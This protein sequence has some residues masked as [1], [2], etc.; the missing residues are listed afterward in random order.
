MRTA[1]CSPRRNVR[2][3]VA[4][5]AATIILTSNA[6]P[7]PTSVA[8]QTF[9]QDSPRDP[10]DTPVTPQP[11]DRCT[12]PTDPTC[13][14]AVYKGAPDDYAQVQDIPAWVL[15]HPD[16]DGRYQ[17]ERGQQITVVTA[18]PLPSRLHPLLPPAPTAAGH[19]QSDIIPSS[20]S[21]RSG[22]LTPSP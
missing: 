4:A 14:L 9:C 22:R 11:P 20:S 18:A 16:D 13:I 19:R 1:L 12:T 15:I 5:V 6:A 17:V 3:L 8:Q 10:P 21:H 2:M 7:P